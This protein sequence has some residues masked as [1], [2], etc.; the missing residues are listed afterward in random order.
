MTGRKSIPEKLNKGKR[1]SL[2]IGIILRREIGFQS[3]TPAGCLLSPGSW[4]GRDSDQAS[5][6]EDSTH[7]CRAKSVGCPGEN[8][9]RNAGKLCPAA[10]E[11]SAALSS[12]PQ[13]NNPQTPGDH[14]GPSEDSFPISSH[15]SFPFALSCLSPFLPPSLPSSRPSF[16]ACIFSSV[17]N[18]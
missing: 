17:T 4:V 18:L 16:P 1:M 7:P 8:M 14:S 10:G 9:L 5:P 6:R 11:K 13:C 12:K 3:H 15:F 2:K